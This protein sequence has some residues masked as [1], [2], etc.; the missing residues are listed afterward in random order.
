M[1]ELHNWIETAVQS[2]RNAQ[3][4]RGLLVQIGERIGIAAKTCD[5]GTVVPDVLVAKIPELIGSMLF[6]SK[7]DLRGAV[8]RGWCS[9]ANENKEMDV[10][11]AEAIVSEVWHLLGRGNA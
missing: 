8:A 2:E 6:F 4:Y 5:D 9:P 1:S 3:Y 7:A 10:T 11:L